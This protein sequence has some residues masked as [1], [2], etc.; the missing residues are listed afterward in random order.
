MSTKIIFN[1]DDFGYCQ[2][3]NYAI[4]DCYH[5]GL[6]KSTTIMANMKGFEQAIRLAKDE[7]DLDVGIHLTLS[8]G[9]PLTDAKSLI[10]P[11]TGKFKKITFFDHGDFVVDTDEVYHELKAQIEKTIKA[12][13]IPTHFDSHQ[14]THTMGSIA[15]VVNQLAD[16]YGVPIRNNKLESGSRFITEGFT[17]VMDDYSM[18][19]A[20]DSYYNYRDQFIRDL[21]AQARKVSSIEVMTHPGYLDYFVYRN[22]SFREPRAID[23]SLLQDPV[24][25]QAIRSSGLE[26]T[27]FKNMKEEK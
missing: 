13:I 15:A 20:P 16:E 27:S 19:I 21:I 6:L 14:H 24:V 4:M 25:I 26:V 18:K 11:E 5:M 12:G 17:M 10:V 1:A 8:C 3:V 23:A 9:K 7:P 22:S 2:S